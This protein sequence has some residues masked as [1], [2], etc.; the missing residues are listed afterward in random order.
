MLD[1][2]DSEIVL[3]L[4][5]Q[6]LQH[7]I[8]QTDIYCNSLWKEIALDWDLRFFF[9]SSLKWLRRYLK[10]KINIKFHFDELDVIRAVDNNYYRK[11]FLRPFQILI[12]L[13]G[14]YYMEMY[15]SAY[16][17]RFHSTVPIE[18]G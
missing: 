16:I 12:I 1:N 7:F 4:A 8:V 10:K 9:H 5:C 17:G 15:F 6:C 14:Y 2:I 11:P 3:N 13:V 18:I